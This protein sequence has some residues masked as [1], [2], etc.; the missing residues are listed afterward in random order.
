MIARRCEYVREK[1]SELIICR[2]N[3]GVRVP[4]IYGFCDSEGVVKSSDGVT[5]TVRETVT[6]PFEFR[7][8]H[9]KGAT[10]TIRCSH[11]V[12]ED[13]RLAKCS[14]QYYNPIRCLFHSQGI[15]AVL[16]REWARLFAR[17][18]LLRRLPMPHDVCLEVGRLLSSLLA[19]ETPQY[20]RESNALLC[21]GGE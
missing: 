19:R 12:G 9:R 13:H 7:P 4:G 15:N 18:P 21:A 3:S 5:F 16:E 17:W 11:V 6:E 20:M 10:Q 2:W 8:P 14:G 1:M